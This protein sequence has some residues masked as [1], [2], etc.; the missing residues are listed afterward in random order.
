MK[1]RK[2]VPGV[3]RDVKDALDRLGIGS[4]KMNGSSLK[5]SLKSPSNKSESPYGFDVFPTGIHM[6]Y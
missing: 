1:P 2:R 4:P 3:P 5:T 6:V